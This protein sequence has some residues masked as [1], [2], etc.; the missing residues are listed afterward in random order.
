MNAESTKFLRKIV[1]AKILC[2]NLWGFGTK[3]DRENI[4]KWRMLDFQNPTDRK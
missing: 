1:S 4:M 2:K 3:R